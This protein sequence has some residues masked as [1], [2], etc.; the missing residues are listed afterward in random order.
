MLLSVKEEENVHSC[1]EGVK[2][3]VDSTLVTTNRTSYG[4]AHLIYYDPRTGRSFRFVLHRKNVRKANIYACASCKTRGK[5]VR[6]MVQNGVFLRDPASLDHI[7]H[8]SSSELEVLRLKKGME[9]LKKRKL[10]LEAT[11][12]NGGFPRAAAKTS[13]ATKPKSSVTWEESAPVLS[14]VDPV[15]K[16]DPVEA[17]NPSSVTVKVELDEDNLPQPR[18]ELQKCEQAPSQMGRTAPPPPRNEVFLESVKMA[19]ESLPESNR[20]DAYVDILHYIYTTIF[21]RYQNP[22]S[23]KSNK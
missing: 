20:E 12:M 1:H 21:R 23:M 13:S 17:K 22:E 10:L 6:I 9:R 3:S 4:E 5:Y 19:V 14:R 11:Y 16:T 7:C 15:I 18:N 8:L 2:V